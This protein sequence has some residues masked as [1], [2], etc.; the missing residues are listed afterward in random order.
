MSPRKSPN[1]GELSHHLPNPADRL[2]HV[3]SQVLLSNAIVPP[4]APRLGSFGASERSAIIRT[5]C[6][7]SVTSSLLLFE[8]S[9]A[10]ADLRAVSYPRS[11]S[12]YCQLDTAMRGYCCSGR[13]GNGSL[14]PL[15]ART[16][17]ILMRPRLTR[18]GSVLLRVHH[19]CCFR[20]YTH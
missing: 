20:R 7:S 12:S 10:V 4:F 18:S 13:R 9:R 11:L 16:R 2:D 5:G 1:L 14:V 15:Q 6:A 8:Q 3:W 17:Y 19:H